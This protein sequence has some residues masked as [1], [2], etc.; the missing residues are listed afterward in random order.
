MSEGARASGSKQP[1]GVSLWQATANPRPDR[2]RLEGRRSV[3]VA[4]IGAGYFGLSA[5][6]ALTEAGKAV[7]VVEAER[8]GWGA[9]GRSAGFVVPN[10]AKVDPEEVIARLGSEAGERLLAAT[11]AS[12][13]L[14]FDLV[15]RH[16]IACDA[17]QSGWIQPAH[18]PNALPRLK[19]RMEAWAGRGRPVAWLDRAAIAEMT[20]CR[21]YPGGW[22]DRSGGVLHPLNYTLGLADA[23]ERAGATIH[24]DSPVSALERAGGQWTVVTAGGAIAADTVVLATNAYGRL[25]GRLARSI[26]PLTVYQIATEPLDPSVR[27]RL[28]PGNQSVSDTARNLFTFRF[29]AANRLISGGMSALPFGAH[30]R[31]PRAI[32]RRM[33]GMLDF[34]DL[35]PIAFA[36][37]G[38]AAVTPDFLPHLYEIAPGVVAGI[39]CNGR[40]IAVSTMLGRSLADRL[41]GLPSAGP[42][43]GPPEP[44]A[45]H[46]LA[47]F[48]PHAFLPYGTIRDRL[49]RRG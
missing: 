40:G 31:A 22:I 4:V 44:F 46:T 15:R 25:D 1:F 12:A 9:S 36:W 39:G 23:A 37:S 49:D 45:M 47:R 11:G 35:P 16:A 27:A 10:F 14:V 28:L 13:D 26:L 20:G 24:E 5:A 33:A 29:D 8:V 17:H 7:A 21:S 18:A 38:V 2:P 6:L 48:A 41:L 42:P 19:A 30:R 34:P 3:D 32:H 43:M